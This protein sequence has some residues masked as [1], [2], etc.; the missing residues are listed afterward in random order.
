MSRP[1]IAIL[2]AAL[3]AMAAAPGAPA[4]DAAAI[5]LHGLP[6]AVPACA[7]CHGPQA[8]GNAALGYPRLAGAPEAYLATQLADLAA[9]RRA[10]V[11]MGPVAKQLSV[12]QQSALAAYLAALPPP[13]VAVPAGPNALGET[14]ALDGRDAGRLPACVSCH[15]PNGMGVGSTFP[16]LAGQPAAYIEGQ[17][18]AWQDG[19]RPP[20][21]LGLMPAIAKRLSNDEIVA[22]SEYFASLASAPEVKQ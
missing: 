6:P 2:A 9:G 18:H 22:V 4:P 1:R 3:L 5:F 16:A 8:L 19:K 15:G 21:P 20:G 10:N 17:L 11:L 7:I 13:P 14:L 12:A